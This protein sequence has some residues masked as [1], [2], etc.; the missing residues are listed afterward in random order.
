MATAVRDFLVEIGTEELPAKQLRLLGENFEHSLSK[1][2]KDMRLLYKETQYFVTPRRLAVYITGLA[3]H[4]YEQSRLR[5]GPALTA[6][7][8]EKGDPTK[9]A[10]GFAQS[11]GVK[12]NELSQETTEKGG[13]LVYDEPQIK[14]SCQ[15]LL[16]E[17]LKKVLYELPINKRMRWGDNEV[18]FLRP[19]KW[20]LLLYGNE[21]IQTNLFGLFSDRKTYGHRFLS[22]DAIE[23]PDAQS[24]EKLLRQAK[25]IVD[26]DKRKHEIKLQ[27]TRET[28]K[29]K[30]HII[31]DKSFEELLEEVTGLVEWPNAI[32]GQFHQKFLSLPKEVLS[33]VLSHHQKSFSVMNSKN[34]LDH[35]F[36]TI[37]NIEG[38]QAYFLI[39]EGNERVVNARLE[40][41]VFFHQKDIVTSMDKY[42][43]LLK[44]LVFQTQLGTVYDKTV[45]MAALAGIV[46]EQLAW[47]KS[48][49]VR[50]AELAKADLM[51]DMVGEFPELQG[52]IGSYYITSFATGESKEV[53]TAIYEH[54][55]PRFADDQLPI[56]NLGIVL[57]LVDRLDT[58]VGLFGINHPPT[59]DKDP[60]GLRRSAIGL[61]RLLIEKEL[62]LNLL[63]LLRIAAYHYNDCLI[64]LDCVN[65]A[66]DFIIERLRAWYAEQQISGDVFCAV[67]VNR[68]ERPLDFDRRIHAV[69]HFSQ[70]KEASALAAAHKRVNNLLNKEMHNMSLVKLDENLFQQPEEKNLAEAIKQKQ[71]SIMPLVTEAR[72][73]EVLIELA[74]L[75]FIIDNFLDNVMVIVDDKQL[76]QNRLTLLYKLRE[77][78]LTVADIS[79]LQIA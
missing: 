1:I 17:I 59:G 16:P 40:D 65:Q 5:R 23:L 47:D 26:F 51:T 56:S 50:A 27:L 55:F 49:A 37:S 38:K 19:V 9:A 70:L 53:A 74:G 77:L 2:L 41:A 24:Y 44:T 43:E 76:K 72:Y 73:K 60:F 21:V 33:T 54:Y 57:A 4:Q 3:E 58:I 61:L 22:P 30:G 31:Q 64:N 6:A 62:N 20:V 7:F 63:E 52:I 18:E 68:P 71:L 78:F 45:R 66:F 8:D 14:R 29:L 79:L 11:C 67:L 46:A 35:F 10:L 75:R 25:V 15:D 48:S 32:L 12:V 69:K 36:V 13:W 34:K 28:E 39:K 42:R